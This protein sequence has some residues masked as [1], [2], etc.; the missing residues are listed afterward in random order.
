MSRSLSDLADNLDRRLG[1]LEQKAS[2]LTVKVAVS[3]VTNLTA[4][5]PVDTSNALS[6]W[7]IGLG[8]PVDDTRRPYFVG[9][10]GSTALASA[11]ATIQTA[12]DILSGK[13]PGEVVF[14]SNL[15]DYIVDLENGSSRQAPSGF[16]QQSI[17][18]TR[19]EMKR[20]RL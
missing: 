20:M 11:Q 7:Q 1:Q 12:K 8:A 14:I 17:L 3:L 9:M 13:K 4:L 6:N 15:V 10:Y 19:N 5:T 2:D 18:K 16:L